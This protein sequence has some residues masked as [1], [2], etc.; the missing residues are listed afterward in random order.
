MKNTITANEL[1]ELCKIYGIDENY[2]MILLR[3]KEEVNL[4]EQTTLRNF[5][6]I[7]S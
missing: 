5:Y 6:G 3:L 4:T 7:A 2:M 1:I